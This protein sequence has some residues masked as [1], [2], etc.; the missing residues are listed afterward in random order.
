MYLYIYIYTHTH[1]P[2]N[3]IWNEM[4]SSKPD[5]FSRRWGKPGFRETHGDFR[6]F[7]SDQTIDPEK[8]G[9]EV[10]TFRTCSPFFV[11]GKKVPNHYIFRSE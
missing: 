8:I 7:F 2:N 6:R 10:V 11:R 1:V 3:V 9:A 5:P 4:A